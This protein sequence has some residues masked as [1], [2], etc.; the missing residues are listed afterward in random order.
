MTGF[1]TAVV[2]LDVE[3]TVDAAVRQA[4]SV[5][6]VSVNGNPE[7]SAQHLRAIQSATR[8]GVE[9][10]VYVSFVLADVDPD[11]A[12]HSRTESALISSGT[13]WTIL[14]N[15]IYHSYFVRQAT[16]WIESGEV[17]GAM[18]DGSASPVCHEDLARAA[19]VV[20]SDGQC[21]SRQY[22]LGS[23]ESITGTDLARSM[24]AATGRIFEY[25]DL[26]VD[27]FVEY[28]ISH[29]MEE[30]IARRRANVDRMIRDGHCHVSTGDLSG[31]IG[32][33]IR[34]LETTLFEAFADQDQ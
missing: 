5:I 31:L 2:D 4:S 29:G 12:D 16:G 33:G 24:S 25:R 26:S 28:L 27:D 7:R 32:G 19:A 9:H 34:S 10:F 3:E 13:P 20:L 17:V 18:G 21:L 15:G 14:R 8:V 22:V 11:H 23:D 30:S 6:L 1:R